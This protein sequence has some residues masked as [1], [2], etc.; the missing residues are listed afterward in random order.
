VSKGDGEQQRGGRRSAAIVIALLAVHLIASPQSVDPFAFFRPSVAVTADDRKQL[1]GG[2]PVGRTLPSDAGEIAVF[3]AVRVGAGPD[4]LVAW[5]RRIAALKK[6][7][8]VLAIG[9]FSDPPRIEDLAE[10][11]LDDEDLADIRA[12]RPGD[13]DLKLSAAEMSHLQRGVRDPGDGWKAAVQTAFR[14]V[15]LERVR[16]YL[17][18]GRAVAA[19]DSRSRPV[20]PADAFKSVLAHSAFLQARPPGLAEYLE[21]YP[22]RQLPGVESFVYWSKERITSRAMIAATHV[23]IVRG[24]GPEEP[25]VLVAG[26]QFFATHYVNASLGVTAMLRGQSDANHYLVYLNR[27]AVD[28]PGGMFGGLV[29]WFAERR[30]KAEAAEV[31]DGLRRRLESGDPPAA[32]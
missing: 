10:L 20:S 9:R 14:L 15:V 5:M 17:S 22:R 31:L 11:T 3:A 32:R 25:E 16:A 27:S 28:L 2:T 7:S 21:G 8:Y 13:C 1:D 19:Y 23:N 29:R 4:R 12:C 18:N 30:V 26:K 24:R 6:S